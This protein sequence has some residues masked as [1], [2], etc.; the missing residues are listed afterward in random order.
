L[1]DID[2]PVVTKSS[3]VSDLESLGLGAGDTVMFHVSVKSIGWV[4][5]GPDVVIHALL[6][7]LGPSGTLM[8]YI[9]SEDPLDGFEH[10]PE[11]RR[12]AYLDHCPPFDP[13]R[14]RAYR[15][16]SILTEYLRTWPGVR[17]SNHP[18]ARIAAL[19]K[20]ADWITKKH[21]LQYG[22]GINSPLER[23]CEANGRILLL[24]APLTTLTILHHAE[25]IAAVPGK[26]TERFSWPMVVS[27]KRKWIEIEQYDTS[28]GIVDWEGGDYFT[29]IATEYMK[30]GAHGVG[31]VG[32]AESLLFS[33]GDLTTFA[34]SWMERNLG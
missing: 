3:L 12:Q 32:S 5:G 11:D 1:P 29:R 10:W 33:A 26:R 18:E 6:D 8:M 31:R 30:L 25:H 9:K 13:Y 15:K 22:Y 21:P 19:G 4:V 23:L 17:C 20:K 24:G 2:L 27:G 28:E 7:V 14:T 16:W 34:V